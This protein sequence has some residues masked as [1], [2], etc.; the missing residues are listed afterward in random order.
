VPSG[1]TRRTDH[2]FKLHGC[3]DIGDFPPAVLG[4]SGYVV[5]I[6]S[7][8]H[9]D[10][11]HVEK[12]FLVLLLVV[13]RFGLAG[14]LTDTAF[15]SLEEPAV[16]GIDDIGGRDGLGKILVNSLSLA[17][18]DVEL[19][20]DFCGALLGTLSTAHTF[21]SLD[22]TGLLDDPGLEAAFLSLDASHF[23]IGQESDVFVIRALNHLGCKD[24]HGTVIG[25]KGFV[26]LSHTTAYAWPLLHQINLVSHVGEIDSGL[27]AGN[28]TA[29]D[30]HSFLS[31]SE[32][33]LLPRYSDVAFLVI[34]KVR[35]PIS[36][37]NTKQ[38]RAEASETRFVAGL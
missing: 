1:G 27:N 33:L 13:Y 9:D 22:K 5:K 11:S 19:I 25:R 7:R 31:Q 4:Q 35:L 29:Y 18:A 2:S 14:L 20:L 32:H 10:G 3:Q 23:T 21:V 30:E 36:S 34:E 26:E 28:A 24:A 6:K 15:L 16:L 38:Q 37:F 12:D 8:G 17:E